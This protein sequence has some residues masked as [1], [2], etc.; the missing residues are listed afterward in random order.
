MEP[1][2]RLIAVDSADPPQVVPED[3]V[4]ISTPRGALEVKTVP[5]ETLADISGAIGGAT[6]VEELTKLS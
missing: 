4:D 2:W 5:L 3:A 6:F 1:N